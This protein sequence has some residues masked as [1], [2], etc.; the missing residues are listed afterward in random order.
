M[1]EGEMAEQVG[2]AANAILDSY[3]AQGKAIF[4]G[5][6]G[7]AAD[8]QH[9]AG[10]FL[11]RYLRDR[12]SLPAVALADG[13]STVTAIANDYGFAEIFSRQLD[14]IARAGDVLVAMSTSGNSE[15]V[16]AAVDRA[17]ELGVVTVG[18]TGAD[19]GAL[20]ERCDHCLR[21]PS[22]QVP[23]I[24]EAHMLIGHALC[25][26]VERELFAP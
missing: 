17:G 26:F 23:R 2:S 4:C 11:G 24:Q 15:N 18:M 22:D 7:S 16:L 9:L 8:A 3:R 1:L 10:E 6:G 13:I 19:G 5:N 14:G 20:A 25:E 21:V 12:R